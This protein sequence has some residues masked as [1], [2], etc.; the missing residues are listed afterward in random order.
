MTG[1]GIDLRPGGAR[2]RAG[3]A[4]CSFGRQLLRCLD[5]LDRLKIIHCDLK[6]ENVLLVPNR[7]T[8]VK[9]ID[10]GSSCFVN[11]TGTKRPR[12]RD[13]V[14]ARTLTCPAMRPRARAARAVRPDAVHTYIQSRFYRSPEIVLGR[15]VAARL[16][17]HP[18]V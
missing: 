1:P 18:G 9:V 6:P 15:R 14:Q 2:S 7:S 10:F 4:I 3:A 8:A 13:R 12:T 16:V 11:E 5:L 17:S